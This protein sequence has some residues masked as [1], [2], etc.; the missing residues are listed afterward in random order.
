LHRIGRAGRF[1]LPGL[2]L[3]LYDRQEDEDALNDILAYYEM[4]DKMQPL[5]DADH[6]KQLL[7]EL[8]VQAGA[9]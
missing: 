1:G 4:T 7:E 8:T 3:T 6:L 2:A 5:K 9:V